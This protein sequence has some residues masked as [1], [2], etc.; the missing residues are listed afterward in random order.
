MTTFIISTI[1]L[2]GAII[3]LVVVSILRKINL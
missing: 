1:L 3:G 2:A